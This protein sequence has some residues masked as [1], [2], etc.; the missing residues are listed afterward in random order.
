M[1]RLF[2]LALTMIFALSLN[3]QNSGLAKFQKSAKQKRDNSRVSASIKKTFNTRS[4]NATNYIDESFATQIPATWTVTTA[5]GTGWFWDDG[6]NRGYGQGC[7]IIDSDAS[8]GLDEGS[9]TSPTVDASGAT[10]LFLEY[11]FNFQKYASQEPDSGWVEVYDGSSWVWLTGYHADSPGTLP[12]LETIDIT[13]YANANLA[14][15]FAYIADWC[16]YF[17]VSD[18]VVYEP[19]TDD[20]GTMSI[21]FGNGLTGAFDPTA[22]VNNYGSTVQTFNVTMNIT[23]GYTAS[24]QTVTTL[25]AGASQQVTFANWNPT[26]G[27]YDVEVYTSLTGDSNNANDTLRQTVVISDLAY[28]NGTIYGYNAYENSGS[29]LE[30]YVVTV[31][32]TTGAQTA[33]AL[34]TTANFLSCGDYVGDSAVYGVEYFTNDLYLVNGNGI[35]VNIGTITGVTEITGMT[36]DGLNDIIYLADWTGT[37]SDLY[38]LDMGT[39]AATLVGPMTNNLVIAIAAGNAGEVWAIDINSDSLLDINTSTGVASPIGYLGV[40]IDYA[41]DIGYDRENDIL[42]GTLYATDGG[43]YTID[44]AT[45]TATLVGTF[46]DEIS[47]CAVAAANS[48]VS[49]QENAT[50]FKMYPNPA[51]NMI[52]INVENDAMLSISDMTGRI[53]HSSQINNTANISVSEYNSGVYFVTVVQ[54][55]NAETIKLIVE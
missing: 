28:T 24:T 20:V 16:W 33:V 12:S 54:N 53:V 40:D 45:G 8:G 46:T 5:N 19:D 32:K 41:Q 50:T 6:T 42:Y 11:N 52:T 30:D 10:S 31:D 44:V 22:T 1:K 43:L 39:M 23:G 3:A 38:T 18:V 55:N 29:G 4:T 17:A 2:T 49:I 35:T 15:R 51:N 27:T 21:D 26:A 47:M 7:A 25:A 13:A 48:T 14:I 9:L 34:G 37:S 36:Y